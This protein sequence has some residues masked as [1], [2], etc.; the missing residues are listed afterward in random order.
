M[1]EHGARPRVSCATHASHD[2]SEIK[3]PKRNAATILYLKYARPRRLSDKGLRTTGE[4]EGKRERSKQGAPARS[5]GLAHRR[6]CPADSRC[7]QRPEG[8][9]CPPVTLRTRLTPS[10]G[11]SGAAFPSASPRGARGSRRRTRLTGRRPVAPGLDPPRCLQSHL[12]AGA[13]GSRGPPPGRASGGRCPSE[14]SGGTAS[15]K[16]DKGHFVGSTKLERA[17]SA[18]TKWL[19]PRRPLQTP[20]D[21]SSLPSATRVPHPAASAARPSPGPGGSGSGGGGKS[22]SRGRHVIHLQMS[23]CSS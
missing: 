11:R 10:P 23:V 2:P 17:A 14:L 16:P 6:P 1:F 18:A 8:L 13:P 7:R 19:P 22:R 20:G 9:F 3:T 15:G 12:S 21:S 5:P 4:N